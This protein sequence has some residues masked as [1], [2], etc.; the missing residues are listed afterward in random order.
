M[1]D[2]HAVPLVD[3]T[4][5]HSVGLL[6]MPQPS[7]LDPRRLRL[8]AKPCATVLNNRVNACS[9]ERRQRSIAER[10]RPDAIATCTTRPNW[11]VPGSVRDASANL[12]RAEVMA[13]SPSHDFRSE[14]AGRHVLKMCRAEAWPGVCGPWC[15]VPRAGSVIL[16]AHQRR[17][18]RHAEPI[19]C[20]ALCPPDRR[21]CWTGAW[22][23][24]SRR[25]ARCP[26]EGG[27]RHD[28]PLLLQGNARRGRRRQAGPAEA[29]AAACGACGARNAR[30][31]AQTD[32]GR[33]P[34][35]PRGRC[36]ERCDLV[37]GI[38]YGF[39]PMSRNGRRC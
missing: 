22:S 32:S 6:R 39:A 29:F 3:P 30:S 13:W 31:A 2:I 27:W 1:S 10:Q 5:E 7:P 33:V 23:A 4:I 18:P 36:G 25:P 34:E 15:S 28:H 26:P 14:R 11:L 19:Y 8:P 24:G 20:L 17:R 9:F 16:P 38:R 35:R 12:S 21:R 37:G